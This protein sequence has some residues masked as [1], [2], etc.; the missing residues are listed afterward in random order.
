LELVAKGRS[1]PG[2]EFIHAKRLCHIVIGPQIKR[3]NLPGLVAA[4]GQ[5]YNRNMLI[6]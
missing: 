2:E 4:A 1:H 3:L 5:Y 6:P